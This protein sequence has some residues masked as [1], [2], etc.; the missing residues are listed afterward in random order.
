MSTTAADD[1]RETLDRINRELDE[2]VTE[3]RAA[4]DQLAVHRLREKQ[5]ML[6]LYSPDGS[7]RLRRA[8]PLG[9]P[10][11]IDWRQQGQAIYVGAL[12]IEPIT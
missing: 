3:L 12:T 9:V 11:H 2:A 5:V 4:V 6:T 7:E 10:F 1:L 8:V